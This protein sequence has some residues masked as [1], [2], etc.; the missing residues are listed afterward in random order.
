M[1][2]TN[3]AFETTITTSKETRDILNKIKEKNNLKNYDNVINRLLTANE[4]VVSKD[5][6]I[7]YAPKIALTLESHVLDENN[8]P[9]NTVKQPIYYSDLKQSQVGKVYSTENVLSERYVFQTAEI[10]YKSTDFILLKVKTLIKQD[11]LEEYS[12]LVGVELLWKGDVG[13]VFI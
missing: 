12:E 5:Y 6:E 10:V 8:V 4:G 9:A 13:W 3:T 1:K 2:R 7:I 11:Q